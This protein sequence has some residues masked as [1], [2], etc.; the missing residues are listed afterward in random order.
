MC[1]KTATR[2]L[3][4]GSGKKNRPWRSWQEVPDDPPSWVKGSKF[5]LEIFSGTGGL[6]GAVKAAGV[7]IYAFDVK[8]FDDTHC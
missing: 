1:G 5:F 6:A 7:I 3:T 8:N 2:I 4:G